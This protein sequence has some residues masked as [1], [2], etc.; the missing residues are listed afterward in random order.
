[1]VV[2][3]TLRSNSMEAVIRNSKLTLLKVQV[4]ASPLT[5][6]LRM[7]SQRMAEDLDM[8]AIPHNSSNTTSNN[9]NNNVLRNLVE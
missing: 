3:N 6:N 7:A 2:I 8:V 1:M 5:D 4:M 9:N